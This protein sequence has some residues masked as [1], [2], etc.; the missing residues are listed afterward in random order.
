MSTRRTCAV[1][2]ILFKCRNLNVKARKR[3]RDDGWCF[4]IIIIVVFGSPQ[5]VD[6]IQFLEICSEKSWAPRW[7]GEL[8]RNDNLIHPPHS[9]LSSVTINTKLMSGKR[10][11]WW[12]IKWQFHCYWKISQKETIKGINS[13][14]NLIYRLI[15]SVLNNYNLTSSMINLQRGWIVE[16]NPLIYV[17]MIGKI[18]FSPFSFI[19]LN[20]A[21]HIQYLYLWTTTPVCT[22]QHFIKFHESTNSIL[23]NHER[24]RKVKNCIL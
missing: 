10:V 11:E 19:S 17:P 12:H 2:R 3:R 20:Y 13:G 7:N 1:Q 8:E 22:K 24:D 23:E 6:N 21:Y 16:K 9:S 15:A 18:V 4:I 5:F 14:E